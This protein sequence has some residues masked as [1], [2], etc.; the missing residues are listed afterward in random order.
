MSIA[1]I[2]RRFGPLFIV[3]GAVL[4]APELVLVGLLALF[5]AALSG[6]WSHVGLRNVRYERVLERD[7]TVWGED[8]PMQISVRNDKL[9]PVAWLS[10]DDVASPNTVIRE[11]PLI[12]RERRHAAIL[13]SHWTLGF[14]ERV[15]RHLHV[16]ADRRG[17]YTFGPVATT[18]A[19]LFGYGVA[20]EQHDDRAI[21]IVRPRTLPVLLRRQRIPERAVRARNT[22][23]EDPALFAG[24]R[25]YHFGDPVKRIHWRAT[26]RTGMEMSK[27]YDPSKTDS[28]LIALDLQTMP[29]PI[30]T[31]DDDLVESLMVAASS[32]A[33]QALLDGAACGIAVMAQSRFLTGLAFLAPRTGRDQLGAIADLLARLESIPSAPF[34]HLLVR[35]PQRV[36]PGTTI[37]VVTARSPDAYAAPLLRL[38][39]LGFPIQVVA[40][41]PNAAPAVSTARTL[42]F[43]AMMGSIT[44]DWRTSDALVLAG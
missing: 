1:D 21:C 35:V 34:E 23:F 2:G 42:G 25:P 26:V 33:R 38:D 32:L 16:S 9:L 29:G 15:V 19:D 28:I 18:V 8:I 37:A 20:T 41:G 43:K 12:T 22:L 3:A 30:W 17:V 5:A 13:R 4:G 6:V 7:R 40:L 27:R 14:H 10:V 44:P 36:T 31:S 11:M 24:V 39:R